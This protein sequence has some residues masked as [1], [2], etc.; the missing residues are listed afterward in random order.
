M[1]K[2]TTTTHTNL[3]PTILASATMGLSGGYD[4]FA[5]PNSS[6]SNANTKQTNNIFSKTGPLPA[7]PQAQDPPTP[8]LQTSSPQTSSPPQADVTI[9][10]QSAYENEDA[11]EIVKLI[12]SREKL[13]SELK[14]IIEGSEAELAVLRASGHENKAKFPREAFDTSLHDIR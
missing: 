1:F 8:T 9:S 5:S 10:F 7:I 12:L 6:P 13:V 11:L 14:S 2:P 3:Q 4:E